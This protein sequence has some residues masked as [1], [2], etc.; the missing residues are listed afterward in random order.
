MNQINFAYDLD[1]VRTKKGKFVIG[2]PGLY[3]NSITSRNLIVNYSGY[4]DKGLDE[5]KQEL[6]TDTLPYIVDDE[7]DFPTKLEPFLDYLVFNTPNYRTFRETVKYYIKHNKKFFY[8]IEILSMDFFTDDPPLLSK[9]LRQAVEKGLGKVLFLQSKEG[10]ALHNNQYKWLETFTTLNN[11]NPDNCF[12]F[13]SNLKEKDTYDLYTQ[14][15][16]CSK[17]VIFFSDYHFENFHW[18]VPLHLRFDSQYYTEHLNSRLIKNK[19]NY[20]DTH[21]LSLNR[22]PHHHRVVLF[23]YLEIY[24]QLKKTTIKSLGRMHS[25]NEFNVHLDLVEKSNAIFLKPSELIYNIKNYKYAQDTTVDVNL[26]ENHAGYINFKLHDRC[27]VNVVTETRI[28]ADSIFFSEKIFKPIFM[29]QPFILLG[30]PF[31]LKKLK[32][33]EYKTFSDWWDESYD[34]ETCLYTRI[35]K[36]VEIMLEIST[37]SL[38]KLNKTLIEMEDILKH[39]F[40]IFISDKRVNTQLEVLKCE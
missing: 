31:S 23:H 30:N 22:R 39:N 32:D 26:E 24:E 3:F 34:N 14:L 11:L 25:V 21:F 40:N 28:D 12:Y 2:T 6:E 1:L 8:P 13:S 19:E 4:F 10:Y 35:Q 9:E 36:I 7:I 18:F 20:L 27:F 15:K 5:I 17:S 16:G 38:E 37:W 29:L 33:M